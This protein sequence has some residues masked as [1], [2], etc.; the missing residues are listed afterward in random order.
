MVR[1][2]VPWG[3]ADRLGSWHARRVDRVLRVIALCAVCGAFGWFAEYAAADGPG[4]ITMF[5]APTAGAI[6]AGPDGSLW[7]TSANGVGRITPSR[8]ITYFP[9]P[10]NGDVGIAAGPDGNIWLTEWGAT[11]IGRITPSGTVT[12][13][14]NGSFGG[15]ITPGPNGTLWYTED[16]CCYSEQ[17]IGRVVIAQTSPGTSDGITHF[18]LSNGDSYPYDIVEGR[19]GNMWFTEQ[20]GLAIG[21]IT[22]EGTVTEFPEP[23]SDLLGITA[24]PDGNIWFTARSGAIGRITPTGTVTMFPVGGGPSDITAGPDGNLWFTQRYSDQIGQ[25]TPSGTIT[26]YQIPIANAQP[27]EIRTGP[28]GNIWFATVADGIGRLSLG[29]STTTSLHCQS[30]SLLVDQ[31]TVCTTTVTD[32]ATTGPTAPTGTVTVSSDSSGT[33]ASDPCTLSGT[34]ATASCEVSYIPAAVGSGQHTLTANYSG[35]STH[36][37][38]TGSRRLAVAAR[39][40]T[41][42]LA[43]SPASMLVG[44]STLCTA[45]V[46]D[47]D[48]GTRVTPSGAV[49][50]DTNGGGFTGTPCTLA[51]SGSSASCEVRW[52]AR[53]VGSGQHPL[54][55]T[56]GGDSAHSGGSALAIVTVTARSTS[57]TIDCQQT[58][59]IVGQ[60]TTCTATVTDTSGGQTTTPTGMVTFGGAKDDS[61]TGSPCMLAG[62]AGVASC[63]VTFTPLAVGTGRHTITASYHG[64]Q[65]H[66]GSH[67]T[68]AIAVTPSAAAN[69][70]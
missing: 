68:A 61:F 49:T 13:Y 38:S 25:I 66:H 58:T 47:I 22:P 56:Y 54:I 21:R 11:D 32:T 60:S 43:C 30:H 53:A 34:G 44:A 7:F 2:C 17:A 57:A 3:V 59:L 16:L 12:E 8:A 46:T 51:G 52:T 20:F 24:G 55:S 42:V 35:D 28:D 26:E 37:P 41:T 62:G 50:F 31:S 48:R 1:N 23:Y 27:G 15:K 63:Q 14:L 10:V 39:A 64:D 18:Q 9:A 36:A 45:T 19:D 70:R 4:T 6:T 67:G 33:F 69:R 5:P 65:Y 29:A 40:T